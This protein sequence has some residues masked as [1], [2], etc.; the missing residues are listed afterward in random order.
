MKINKLLNLLT[1]RNLSS[2]SCKLAVPVHAWGPPQQVFQVSK[3]LPFRWVETPE[4]PGPRVL[5]LFHISSPVLD[6]LFQ[7]QQAGIWDRRRM[8]VPVGKGIKMWA[9]PRPGSRAP[10]RHSA[11]TEQE[12]TQRPP[13]PWLLPPV[14]PA[15]EN[16]VNPLAL[17]TLAGS[18]HSFSGRL[19]CKHGYFLRLEQWRR[20]GY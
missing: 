20:H 10:A 6:P 8:S 14:P 3:C 7:P 12:P 15:L 13:Q 17:C 11:P 16:A 1:F 4:A 9:P 5:F 18:S 19:S 2:I